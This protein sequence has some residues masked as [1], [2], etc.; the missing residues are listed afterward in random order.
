VRKLLIDGL[1]QAE[2]ASALGVSRPTVCFHMR[3]LGVRARPD[4][5]R[6]YDWQEIAAYYEAGHS[7]TA[8]RR[9]FG[10]SR[11]AWGDAIRRGVI[12]P[13][14]RAEPLGLSGGHARSRLNS[15]TSTGTD[16]IIA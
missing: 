1:T 3:Q 4:F 14:P 9:Q 13:R 10:F 16:W 12:D 2:I 5:A 15:T 8:C 11:N 7:F 6:R